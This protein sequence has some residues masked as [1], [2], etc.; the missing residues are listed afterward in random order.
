MQVNNHILQ[1]PTLACLRRPILPPPPVRREAEEEG[2]HKIK[3]ELDES[4]L[5][6]T[7][8]KS[9]SLLKKKTTKIN[10]QKNTTYKI[11]GK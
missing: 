1:V 5:S 7:L 11:F 2:G 6:L 4:D 9:W 3:K 8:K 10:E